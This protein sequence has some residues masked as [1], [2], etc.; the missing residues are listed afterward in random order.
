MQQFSAKAEGL[1]HDGIGAMRG[2]TG[3]NAGAPKTGR[4]KYPQL[5]KSHP[6]DAPLEH[7]SHD[8]ALDHKT[9]KPLISQQLLSKFWMSLG[10]LELSLGRHDWIRTNDLFRVKEAL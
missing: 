5:E 2:I 8:T 1:A 9:Q 3:D 10:Y 4:A 7:G 6:R